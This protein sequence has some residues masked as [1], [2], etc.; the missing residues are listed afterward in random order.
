MPQEIFK[1]PYPFVVESGQ[2]LPEIQITYHTYGNLNPEK[3]NVVWVCHALTANSDVLDWWKGLFGE[4]NLFNPEEHFIICANILGSCYGTTGPLSLNPTT[5]QPYY[6]DFPPITTRDMVK[7]HDLLRQ[8]LE[9][10]QIHTVIGGSLG[11]QQALEWAIQ[12]PQ[13]IQNLIVVATNAYHSPWGIG[14]N[15][16]QR[17]AIFAD[18]SYYHNK[19]DGG[20]QGLKAARA[21]A[22]L[23]YRNY[24]TY[25]KTQ[26]ESDL[27]KTDNFRASSYQNYQGEKLVNRFNAYAY[28]SLSRT[29]D[30]HNV[31][32]HRGSVEEGLAQV[33]AKTLVIGISSDVLFPVSEQR[34]IAQHIKN[35]S[36]QEIDSFY[37]HDGFLI[38]TGQLTQLIEAFYGVPVE[39]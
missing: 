33:K 36:Y 7:A 16:A 10:E 27:A 3:N 21:V 37:G 35:A 29:M 18:E 24:D 4:Q 23:S 19:P 32:R 5:N 20:R 6:Q 13:H 1:Y 11:G 15:E 30:S 26:F 12:K 2:T 28:V 34:Y 8:H 38:E 22:L 31:G 17:L 14:F 25:T 39:K 9:I